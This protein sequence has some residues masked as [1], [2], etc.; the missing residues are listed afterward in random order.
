MPASALRIGSSGSTTRAQARRI[1]QM[2][3]AGAAAALLGGAIGTEIEL[4]VELETDDESGLFP[5][6]V[7]ARGDFFDVTVEHVTAD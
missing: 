3:V 1:A 4:E 7:L 6:D 2:L 5:R